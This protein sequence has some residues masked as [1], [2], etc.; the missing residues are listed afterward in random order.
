MEPLTTGLDQIL[1][2][3]MAD[4]IDGKIDDPKTAD[5]IREVAK[6]LGALA[7]QALV[8]RYGL[9]WGG[10]VGSLANKAIG[11]AFEKFIAEHTKA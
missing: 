8:A 7:S 6:N 9:L 4:L 10:L 2:D 1:A 3:I 5:E 11:D